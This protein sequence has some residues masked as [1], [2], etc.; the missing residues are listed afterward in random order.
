MKVLFILYHPVDPYIVFDTAKKIEEGGGDTFF[1]ILEKEKIIKRIVD[2]YGFKNK[3][4]GKSKISLAGKLVNIFT[5][6]FRINSKIISFRPD[7]IFSATTPYSSF[8]CK[9]NKIP[10][11]CWEDTETATFNWK[12]SHKRINSILLIESYFKKTPFENI[13]RFNG[14]KELAYLHPN[15]FK[16]DKKVLAN[17]GL[18]ESDRIILMRFSAMNAM[19]D[20]GLKS[21][22]ISQ[23]EKILFFIKRAENQYNAKVLISMTER[24]LDAR[25]HRYRLNLEP[26]KYLHLLA[27]CTLYIG[28]GTTTACEAGVLGVPWIALRD[29]ALGYLID[30]EN[31]YALG[32]RIENLDDALK[33]AEIYLSNNNIKAEWQL[34]RKKLLSEKIDV[35]AFITWFLTNYPKSHVIMKK[36]PDFQFKFK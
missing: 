6:F 5:T 10:L 33:Q 2:S 16:P 17:L 35:S 18:K 11:V 13:I 31:N 15:Y 25:F 9:F 23:E 12:Y 28:E 4:I 21:E 36:D 20:I 24:D 14:Y 27:F 3:V 29:K 26:S 8:A 34:K 32:K 22:A 30:Q 19:H 7:L 1:L